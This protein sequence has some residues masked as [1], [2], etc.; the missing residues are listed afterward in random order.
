MCPLELQN[1]NFL[2]ERIDSSSVAVHL[3]IMMTAID[4]VEAL[5]LTAK[6]RSEVKIVVI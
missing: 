6:N 4:R 2:S 1:G 3:P 5:K